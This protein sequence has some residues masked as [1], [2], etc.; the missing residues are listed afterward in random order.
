[1]QPRMALAPARPS[2]VVRAQVC[3]EIGIGAVDYRRVVT[4]QKAS[5]GGDAGHKQDEPDEWRLPISGGFSCVAQIQCQRKPVTTVVDDGVFHRPS[6]RVEHGTIAAEHGSAELDFQQ[7][8]QAPVGRHRGQFLDGLVGNDAAALA[9]QFVE[10]AAEIV[11]G[12][13]GETWM[14]IGTKV[15]LRPAFPTAYAV[16]TK[17][18]AI[19]H[20]PQSLCGLDRYRLHCCFDRVGLNLHALG[21][22]LLG[23]AVPCA[24]ARIYPWLHDMR[25]NTGLAFQAAFGDKTPDG[26]SQG[27]AADAQGSRQRHLVWQ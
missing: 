13:Q 11:L 16:Q 9:N 26:C 7:T 10:R 25:P 17:R 4:E 1:M 21:L 18:L 12:T 5:N 6:T 27:V 20:N 8:C 24:H 3:L 15:N 19:R 23:K 14:K 22:H 2:W